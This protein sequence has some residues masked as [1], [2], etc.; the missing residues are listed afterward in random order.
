MQFNSYIFILAF[1]PLFLIVYYL[2][3]KINKKYSRIIIIIGGMVFYLYAG[4]SSFLVLLGSCIFNII[5]YKTLQRTDKG[6]KILLVAGVIIN[7]IPLIVFKYTSFAITSI[8]DIFNTQYTVTNLILPLGISFFSFQQIMY[9]VGVYKREIDN[10]GVVD[11]LAYVFYFPKLVMGPI[12]EPN[13]LL[14]QFNDDEKKAINTDNIASGIKVFCYGFFKKMILADTFTK[15]V[16]WGFENIDSATAGDFILVMLFY[17]FEIYFD[18]SGYTDMAV[19]ISKMINIELPINFDSPYKALSIRDFWRRWHI[20]L[21]KFFTKYVYFPLGGS[22]KGSIRTYANIMIVFLISGLWHGANWTF[23]LWGGV[24]GF[25]QVLERVFDKYYNKLFIVVRWMYA[26]GAVNVL[27]LLFRSDSITQWLMI[28]HKVF[29]FKNLNV[30]DGMIK[31]INLPELSTMLNT[32]GLS[33]AN[34]AVRGLCPIL[35]LILGFIFCLV[36]N[37]NYKTQNRINVFNLVVA[38]VVFLWSFLSLGNES[39]FVYFNF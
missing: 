17:T 24:H 15:G 11:Y 28:L 5:I 30:S 36:P 35:F 21:T 13:D 27:W 16:S 25:L 31:A 20:S 2:T 32:V 8:N 38:A 1:L 26:F 37:N 3:N 9:V 23:I 6:R 4:T 39:V 22:R 12:T 34:T 29:G 19:G 33:G 10:T 18:F 14:K 7:I